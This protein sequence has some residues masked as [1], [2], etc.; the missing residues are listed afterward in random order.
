MRN[1]AILVLSTFL[2][3]FIGFRF[4]DSLIPVPGWLVKLVARDERVDTA[5]EYARVAG[6]I[7]G[8][9]NGAFFGLLIGAAIV[10][11]LIYQAKKRPAR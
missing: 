3:T 2:G 4:G 1:G 5:V 9:L 7:W 11:L 10:G 6:K 8:G